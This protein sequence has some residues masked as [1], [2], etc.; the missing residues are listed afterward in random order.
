MPTTRV[1]TTN[2]DDDDGIWDG[3]P[4]TGPD[5]TTKGTTG[6]EASCLPVLEVIFFPSF[7]FFNQ[8]TYYQQEQDEDLQGCQH[9]LEGCRGTPR[10][11]RRGIPAR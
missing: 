9:G 3:D 11:P 10:D 8:L 4:I 2:D 1:H 6:Q 5:Y 7:L